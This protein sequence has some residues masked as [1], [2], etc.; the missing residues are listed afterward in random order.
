MEKMKSKEEKVQHAMAFVWLVVRRQTTKW[1]ESF[2]LTLKHT[3]E[4]GF[5][6]R[7]QKIESSIGVQTSNFMLLLLWSDLLIKHNKLWVTFLDVLMKS[8]QKH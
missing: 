5:F 1:S 7:L 4:F 2:K 8:Y 3:S 6:N